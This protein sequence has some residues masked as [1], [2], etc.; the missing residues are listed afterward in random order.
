MHHLGREALAQR[1]LGLLAGGN[2]REWGHVILELLQR[3]DETFREQIPAQAQGLPELHESPAQALH[4]MAQALAR[5]LGQP[6]EPRPGGP[7]P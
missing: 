7:E 4:F 6:N 3:L 2:A 1:P 5:R